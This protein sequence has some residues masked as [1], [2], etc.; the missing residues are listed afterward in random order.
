[1]SGAEEEVG[2]DHES[3]RYI[4]HRK[5]GAGNL[6]QIDL[7]ATNLLTLLPLIQRACSQLLQEQTTRIVRD[8]RGSA[9]VPM[10]VQGY[11]V[12]IDLFHKDELFLTLADA[13]GNHFAFSLSPNDAVMI[14]KRLAEQVRALDQ[15]KRPPQTRQ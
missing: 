15:A 1:M 5:G 12:N 8:Q 3:G 4:L 10:T 6:T 2:L 14:A 7:T 11:D 13:F 9:I